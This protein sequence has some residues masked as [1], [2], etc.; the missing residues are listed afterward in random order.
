[1]AL[2]HFQLIVVALVFFVTFGLSYGVFSWHSYDTEFWK[3]TN[4]YPE[5]FLEL[6]IVKENCREAL[7]DGY[8]LGYCSKELGTL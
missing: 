4:G 3:D 5:P 6:L 7:D 1:M 2:K 8:R